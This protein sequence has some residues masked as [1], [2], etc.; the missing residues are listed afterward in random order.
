M[1]N[2]IYQTPEAK[3]F[4]IE[5][6]ACLAASAAVEPEAKS[7]ST[8]NANSSDST[9]SKKLK[10]GKIIVL[11]ARPKALFA[12]VKVSI[13]G[14]TIEEITDKGKFVLDIDKDC[15]I[16]FKWNQ[17]FSKKSIEGRSNEIKIVKLTW[18]QMNIN[19]EEILY[20]KDGVK[21]FDGNSD[22][23]NSGLKTGLK[24]AGAA[25]GIAAA[26]LGGDAD[27]DFDGDFDLDELDLDGD[28]IADAVGAIGDGIIENDILPVECEDGLL[29]AVSDIAADSDQVAINDQVMEGTDRKA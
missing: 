18:G 13:N 14:D 11:A 27:F 16:D 23:G 10:M 26:L 8:P 15:T 25:I 7:V 12:K 19:L 9:G 6:S 24:V 17:A 1:K 21:V 4:H 3:V 22:G 5:T 2:S 29:D 28:G 20:A